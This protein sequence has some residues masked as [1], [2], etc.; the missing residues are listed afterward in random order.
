M[1]RTWQTQKSKRYKTYKL[2]SQLNTIT[3]GLS[4]LPVIQN[5]SRYV[6]F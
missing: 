4:I 6:T 2:S 5:N 1:Q 3:N